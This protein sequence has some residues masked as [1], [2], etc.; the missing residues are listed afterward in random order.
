MISIRG[1]A[2]KTSPSLGTDTHFVVLRGQVLDTFKVEA[3]ENTLVAKVILCA[4]TR[5]FN[6]S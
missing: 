5:C 6:R 2:Y 1:I 4:T 3:L